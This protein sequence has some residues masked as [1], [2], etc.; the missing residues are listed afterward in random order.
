MF[1]IKY[2][3]ICIVSAESSI[4][5]AADNHEFFLNRLVLFF[6]GQPSGKKGRPLIK[7]LLIKKTTLVPRW[8]LKSR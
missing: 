2:Q 3:L 6:F 1:V 4:C 8:L 5:I 7:V